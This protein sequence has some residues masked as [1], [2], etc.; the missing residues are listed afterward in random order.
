MKLIDFHTHFYPDSIAE[1]T[2]KMLEDMAHTTLFGNGTV[3]SLIEHQ[4]N[5]GVTLSINC[6]IATKPSQVQSINR[7]M[8]EHNSSDKSKDVLCLGTMHP[9]FSNEGDIEEEIQMLAIAGIKGIKMHPEFQDFYPDDE[10]MKKIYKTCKLAGIFI[11]FHSGA[12]DSYETVHGSPERFLKI[13]GEGV[14]VL[15]HLG[16][17]KMWDEVFDKLAGKDFYFDTALV[18]VCE[19]PKLIKSIIQKHG[20]EKILFGTDFP[21]TTAGM[22]KKYLKTIVTDDAAMERICYKNAEKLLGI[23]AVESK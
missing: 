22:V 4:K 7:K 14:F 5:D 8:I 9:D 3:N 11:L 19:E 12:D 23:N 10:I 20:A 21:W 2:I 17:F 1:S 16:A 18:N 15:A 6:P 13:E